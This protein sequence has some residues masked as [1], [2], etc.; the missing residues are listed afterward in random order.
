MYVY[1]VLN[2][3]MDGSH[4]Y[5]NSLLKFRVT[6]SIIISKKNWQRTFN[7]MAALVLILYSEKVNLRHYNLR[8]LT[9]RRWKWGNYRNF[10]SPIIWRGF[11]LV[12]HHRL[13]CFT[14]V[15]SVFARCN[16]HHYNKIFLIHKLFTPLLVNFYPNDE[17]MRAR[18][19]PKRRTTTTTTT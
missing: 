11:W 14:E 7:K 8:I 16:L 5:K 10:N 6:F 13:G 4:S 2:S 9:G 1:I 18:G 19:N 15:N 12:L 17:T 3:K